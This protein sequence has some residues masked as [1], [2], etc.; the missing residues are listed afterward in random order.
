M[1]V[2][3]DGGRGW[4]GVVNKKSRPELQTK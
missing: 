1:E 4:L 3:G 2:V